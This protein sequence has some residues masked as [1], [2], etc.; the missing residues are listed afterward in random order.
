M[1]RKITLLIAALSVAVLPSVMPAGAAAAGTVITAAPGGFSAGYT[2][3]AMVAQV[4]GLLTFVN[5]DIQ[6]HDVV[7]VQSGP[8]TD[9]SGVKRLFASHL[10]PAGRTSVV[11]GLENVVAG[12]V[13]DFTCS[14]HP[15]MKGKL[16][17]LP[18]A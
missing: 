4:S 7:S 12:T 10:I 16:V 15:N 3:P 2:P 8:L 9:D 5:A 17:A 18:A 14:I 13:Y 11:L 1:I 6:Q